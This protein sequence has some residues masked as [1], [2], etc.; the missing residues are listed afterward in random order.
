MAGNLCVLF[1]ELR[2]KDRAQIYKLRIVAMK[3]PRRYQ[4]TGWIDALAALLLLSGTAS[5]ITINLPTEDGSLEIVFEIDE[6]EVNS[7]CGGAI[8]LVLKKVFA[9]A[10]FF[11][12]GS[13][14]SN[15]L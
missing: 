6:L 15:L 10:M 5:A 13:S 3:F 14:R 8:L 12:L 9:A 1:C 2:R 11:F 7:I 4:L